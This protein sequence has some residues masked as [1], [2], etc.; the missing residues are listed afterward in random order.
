MNKTIEKINHLIQ[1]ELA[2]IINRQIELESNVLIS[3][4]RVVTVSNL[5]LAQVGINCFP[6]DKEKEVIKIL[7]KNK[8]R[9][10]QELGKKVKLR[11]MPDLRFYID[12]DGQAELEAREE[13]DRILDSLK[14]D[15]H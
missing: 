1:E 9:L 10:K 15:N 5:S 11:R 14:Q 12:K 2:E 6:S 3:I 13:V 7:H 4:S 8:G